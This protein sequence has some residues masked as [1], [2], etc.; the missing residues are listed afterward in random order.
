[1]KSSWIGSRAISALLTGS[2]WAVV[3][4][5]LLTV[6]DWPPPFDQFE[7]A[8]DG[9]HAMTVVFMLC[10]AVG[11]LGLLIIIIGM[12]IFCLFED[13]SSVRAKILWFLVFFFTVPVGSLVYFFTVYRKLIAIQGEE[14]NG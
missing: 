3:G 4:A 2:A 12:A 13:R 6:L 7:Q 1:M 14:A 8:G 10:F 11:M 9:N 5:L